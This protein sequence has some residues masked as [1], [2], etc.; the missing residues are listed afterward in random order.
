MAGDVGAALKRGREDEAD[1]ALLDDVG[2]AVPD[3]GLEP[4]VRRL[5]EAERLG[6][7]VGRL[8]RVADVHLDVID[9]ME[10]H[11]VPVGDGVGD[12]LGNGVGRH[13]LLLG[14][15]CT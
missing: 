3:P 4:G 12:C 7:E 9:A 8:R 14:C 10:R 5:T 1:A 15:A 6:E 11:L 2:G 13:A